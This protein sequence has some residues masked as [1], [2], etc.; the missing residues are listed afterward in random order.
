MKYPCDIT[1]LQ[2]GEDAYWVVKSKVLE[3]VVSQGDTP[4]EALMIFDELEQAWLDACK[5]DNLEIPELIAVIEPIY[6]G[7]ISLRMSKS[8]HEMAAKTAENQ[9]ISLNQYIN[10]AVIARNVNANTVK[11]L[12][13]MN[14]NYNK[15]KPLWDMRQ[16]NIYPT[17]PLAKSEVGRQLQPTR[18]QYS[19]ILPIA[20][21]L[22]KAATN[23]S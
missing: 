4:E 5:E 13:E 3:H 16:N 12:T 9:N 20:S 15:E 6:S 11:L 8:T 17:E 1:Y 18:P 14:T 10:E 19:Y 7:K 21:V 22:E 23:N 2:E